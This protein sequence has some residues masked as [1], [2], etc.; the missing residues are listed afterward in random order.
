MG[1]VALQHV[2]SSQ[3]RDRT[4]VPHI[5]RQILNHWTTREI[6][7]SFNKVHFTSFPFMNCACG[8]KSGL[9]YQGF[10]LFFFPKI[11][12]V[13]YSTCKSMIHCELIF[14]KDVSVR[15]GFIFCLWL[16]SYSSPFIEETVF[17]PLICFA[18]LSNIIGHICVCLLVSYSIP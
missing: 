14:I 17:P 16:S 18:P 1:V 8:V 12:M 7:D 6:P 11:F 9:R 13:L 2:G 10:S 15:L 5:G 4:P 3:T